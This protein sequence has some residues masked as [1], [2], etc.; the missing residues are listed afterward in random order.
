[1]LCILQKSNHSKKWKSSL[2]E[3]RFYFIIMK[4][5]IRKVWAKYI[6]RGGYPVILKGYRGLS[7]LLY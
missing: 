7:D 2:Q 5:D 4:F 3:K 6:G 1:M